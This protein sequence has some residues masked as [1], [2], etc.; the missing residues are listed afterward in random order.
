MSNSKSFVFLVLTCFYLT[1]AIETFSQGQ[2]T[3]QPPGQ[4]T[5]PNAP[6]ELP[7]FLVTGKA[8]VDI[9]AGAKQTPQKPFR[10]ST[11]ELDSLNPTEKFP[12]PSVPNRSMPKFN[13]SRSV[14][15][16]YVDASFGSYTTPE[17]A[18]GTEFTAGDY[19]I[20]AAFDGLYA[21]DWTPGASIVN[22]GL[23][24]SSSYEAPEKFYLF[25]KGLTETDLLVRHNEY[26]L[27]ADSTAP[28]RSTTRMHAAVATEAVVADIPIAAQLHWNSHNVI[29]QGADG[30][31]DQRIRGRV[32][33]QLAKSY[34]GAFDIDLQSRGDASY[35]FMQAAIGKTF[36]DSL[37]RMRATLGAQ[38]AA[39]TAAQSRV[40]LLADLGAEYEADE[41]MSYDLSLRSGMRA[42]SFAEQLII[43]PYVSASSLIDVPY[44]LLNVAATVKY[45]PSQQLQVLGRVSAIR[46]V[47]SPIWVGAAS[48]QFDLAYHEVTLLAGSMEMIFRP[49]ARD[50]LSAS[51]TA[52]SARLATGLEATYVEPVRIDATYQRTFSPDLQTVLS[53]QYVGRRY[54]DLENS[55]QLDAFLNVQIRAS[56]ALSKTLDIQVLADNLINSTI[57][58]WNGYRE[59]GIFV[60]GGVSMRF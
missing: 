17:L 34:R 19:I 30:V 32:Q 58:V 29:D 24:L 11:S 52:Q 3:S 49:T 38:L 33:A 26:T 4:Q 1:G 51:A 59:R 40:G 60:S 15:H 42:L 22:A 14:H 20:D 53:M 9:A 57:I 18:V 47:R 36:G 23:A 31:R 8:V 6:L 2:S 43:N 13:R 55:R 28:A 12:A 48:F 44:E 50:V 35:P 45:H 56:Y 46:T 21:D 37:L 25:G 54:V 41:F 5:P 10:L 27:F 7:D 16:S 39:S